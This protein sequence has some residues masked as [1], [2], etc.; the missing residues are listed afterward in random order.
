MKHLMV[1]LLFFYT[2]STAQASALKLGQNDAHDTTFLSVEQALRPTIQ[3]D[4]SNLYLEIAITDQCCYLYQKSLSVESKTNGIQMGLSTLPEGIEKEDEVFGPMIVYEDNVAVTIP[5]PAAASQFDFVLHYQGC[6]KSGFCYPPIS[7]TYHVDNMV[8]TAIDGEPTAIPITA[9]PSQI[10]Q[11]AP[12]TP[13]HFDF[14]AFLKYFTIGLLLALTPCVLPMLPI[15]SGIILGQK[16]IGWKKSLGISLSYVLAMSVTYAFA[17]ILAATLGVSLQGMLQTPWVIGSFALLLV[18]MALWLFD[19]I[20]LSGLNH[21]YNKIE[22]WTRQR[23]WANAYVSAAI[24]GVLATLI[25]SPCVTAPLVGVLSYIAQTQ[26]RLH[27]GLALFSMGLGLGVPLLLVAVL[28]PQILPK[29]GAWMQQ[30]SHAFGAML[31]GLAIYLLERV[32]PGQITLAL[33]ALWFVWISF[34]LGIHRKNASFYGSRLATLAFMYGLLLGVGVFH[35]ETTLDYPLRILRA[36]QP[37]TTATTATTAT[38]FIKVTD[39]NALQAHLL[40]AKAKQQPVL[41]DFYADWCVSCQH[42][43]QY[44]HDPEI[45]Q[46]LASWKRLQVDLSTLSPEIRQIMAEYQV[47]A[48]PTFI[49]YDASGNHL[50]QITKVGEVTK[51]E[52]YQLLKT[53]HS[54]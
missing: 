39:L 30:V 40:D 25:A 38:T 24:M 36:S 52:F 28:G 45:S 33:W 53:I 32:L 46:H 22:P 11:N 8:I 34:L 6:A 2:F 5:R 18:L 16:D 19:V 29:K 3:S 43:E 26:D 23:R 35:Q 51:G 48:P 49:F 17:G 37:I 54:L 10:I 1:T 50:S 44:F 4:D 9:S 20:N 15:L 31:I 21:L 13:A 41:L 14:F 47:I 7:Q 12:L 27:G 42:M